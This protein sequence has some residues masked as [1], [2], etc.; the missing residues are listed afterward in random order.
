MNTY[1]IFSWWHVR[2]RDMSLARE[3]Q[4]SLWAKGSLRLL[5]NAQGM[6]LGGSS[7]CV[8]RF[9]DEEPRFRRPGQ[10]QEQG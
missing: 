9:L 8:I 4:T 7:S 2:G 6:C 3:G 10:K 5:G 1:G